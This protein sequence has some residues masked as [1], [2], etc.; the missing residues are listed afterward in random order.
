M[1][2]R[3]CVS[4]YM[5]F[6]TFLVWSCTVPVG[7]FFRHSFDDEISLKVGYVIDGVFF[8]TISWFFYERYRNMRQSLANIEEE[9]VD[10]EIQIRSGE[11]PPSIQIVDV[12]NIDDAY[13]AICLETTPVDVCMLKCGHKFHTEC[14]R[15]HLGYNRTCPLCRDEVSPT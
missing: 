10:N 12:N 5:T 14:L 8:T 7:I 2:S 15:R 1:Y 4:K 6:V 11:L 3:L 9:P 13:C